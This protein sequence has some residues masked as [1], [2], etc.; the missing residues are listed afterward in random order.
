MRIVLDIFLRN[1]SSIAAILI[2]VYNEMEIRE[3]LP[4]GVSGTS[5]FARKA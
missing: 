3:L 5:N 1:L 4:G 2:K